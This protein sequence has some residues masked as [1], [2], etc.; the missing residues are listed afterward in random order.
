MNAP[1]LTASSRRAGRAWLVGAAIAALLL[2]VLPVSAAAAAD[3]VTWTVR[4]AS[5]SLG[6]DRTNFTYTIDPGGSLTD[7][8][9]VANHGTD[10]VTL[11]VYASDGFTSDDGQLSLLVADEPSK[12]I[13]AWITPQ[14]GVITVAPGE[15]V[16]VPFTVAVPDA[17][18]PGDYAG[19]IV[20]SLT[21]PDAAAGV[22]VDRRLGIRVNLRVGGEL[23]PALAVEDT[24]VTWGG[25]L[26][27]FAGADATIT[28][29]LH[30]VGNTAIS[31]HPAA[32]VS[33]PSACSR[34]MP[35]TPAT[36]PSCSRE[37]RGH[38]R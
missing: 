34:W 38:R 18:T 10:P 17:A 27:P 7:A 24:V 6:S 31:A 5:N 37:S 21:V 4:T 22:N 30:N 29:T 16:T 19:G 14:N 9:V 8:L 11:E 12:A 15:D 26:N 23:A 33:G 36:S 3:E 2:P 1:S 28:Y 32:Q 20:T 13:G 25:G 35:W